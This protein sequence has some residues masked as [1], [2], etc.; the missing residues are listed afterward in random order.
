[1]ANF[2]KCA[3]CRLLTIN[4]DEEIAAHRLWHKDWDAK[5][6]NTRSAAIEARDALGSLRGQIASYGQQLDSQPIAE[7]ESITVDEFD[8]DDDE[9]DDLELDQ[10]SDAEQQPETTVDLADYTSYLPAIDRDDDLDTRL[11]NATGTVDLT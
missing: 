3:D 2:A 4:R 7:P 5:F 8:L 9:D 1:M 11:A 6:R 10:I